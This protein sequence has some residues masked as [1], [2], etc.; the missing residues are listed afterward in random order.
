[1][2][3]IDA[4]AFESDTGKIETVAANFTIPSA[5]LRGVA[6]GGIGTVGGRIRAASTIVGI[7]VGIIL[8]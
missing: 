6:T 2:D 5:G 4:D 1:M 3:L 7:S 8:G